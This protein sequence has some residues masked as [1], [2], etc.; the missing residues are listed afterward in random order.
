M[1]FYDKSFWD[2]VCGLDINTITAIMSVLIAATALWVSIR[3]DK[4]SENKARL[5]N[6]RSEKHNRLSVKP[7]LSCVRDLKVEQGIRLVTLK[8]VNSGVGPAVITKFIL[9]DGDEIVSCNNSVAGYVFL[10]EEL[11]P[12]VLEPDNAKIGLFTGGDVLQAG[13]EHLVWKFKYT[14]QSGALQFTNRISFLVEYQSIYQDE[15]FTFDSREQRK[16]NGE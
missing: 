8:F 7:F 14:P 1:C 12:L 2:L 13:E 16:I 15:V 10:I 9:M 5:S 6:E 4:R 3:S 11:K